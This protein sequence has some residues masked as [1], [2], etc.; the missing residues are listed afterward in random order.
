VTLAN[1]S[2]NGSPLDSLRI[3]LAHDYL[4]QP[5]GAEK[6]VEVFAEMFPD[7][8]LYTSLYDRNAMP[9]IWRGVDIRTSFMQRITS[10][11]SLAKALVPLYPAA[12]ELFDLRQYD[13]VLSS[14]TAFAK[15][16]ITRPETCHV[17]YC[18]NP[19]R[20]VWM[21]HDYL[22]HETLPAAVKVMLP[23]LATPLRVW[24]YAAAQRV[25]YFIAGS[26]NAARR[27]K[28]YYRR[29]SDILQAPVDCSVFQPADE[30]G[31]FFLVASRLLAYKRIDLAVEACSRLGLPLKVVGE[32]ADR[33]RL[34]ALAGPTVQFLG[35]A[36]DA[37]L[38]SLMA[39]CRALIFPGEED[40]GL[41]PLEAQAAGRPVIA[42]G[43]G[44]A[45]ETVRAGE[46]GTFF[47]EQ[48]VDAL[49][50][51]LNSFEDNFDSA[52]LR[53]NAL[54]FDKEVFKVRLR[55][56]LA[57]RYEEHVQT[58]KEIGIGTLRSRNH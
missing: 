19:T 48:T 34:E 7:A 17:C 36:S 25:D 26:V 54:R 56:L 16:I 43:A 11:L 8:P 40:F 28:K 2:S 44:G 21:Y 5:G 51:I 53:E 52:I 33:R 22:S 9:D 10:R 18:N 15:G 4:N 30:T 49:A 46:T 32:G 47:A 23:A 12:F 42:Y 3:A 35:R 38:R 29:D 39:R 31:N 41:T 6:V 55:D 37:E 57:R 20:F 50:M 13:L 45:L 58:M 27:I 24:D 14:T 1:S